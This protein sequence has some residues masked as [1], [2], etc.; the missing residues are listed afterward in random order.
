MEAPRRISALWLL[1]LLSQ[2]TRWDV[3]DISWIGFVVLTAVGV[4]AKAVGTR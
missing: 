3:I 2:S 4:T 1:K